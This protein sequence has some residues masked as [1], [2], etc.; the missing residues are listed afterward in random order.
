MKVIKDVK[1]C[2]F[3]LSKVV[4]YPNTEATRNNAN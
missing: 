2:G 3:G 4:S 1:A